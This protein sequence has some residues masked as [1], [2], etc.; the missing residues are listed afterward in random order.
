MKQLNPAVV[1]QPNQ[2][3]TPFPE[4]PRFQDRQLFYFFRQSFV[5]TAPTVF[6]AE[7]WSPTS[8][9]ACQRY[10]ATWHAA[11]AI[12]AFFSADPAAP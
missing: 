5:L 12:A 6:D 10:P 4:I 8:L 11:L 1:H 3:F 9:L 7:F 2:A